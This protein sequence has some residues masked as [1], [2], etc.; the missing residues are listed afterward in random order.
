[1]AGAPFCGW[2]QDGARDVMRDGYL[3]LV[4]GLEWAGVRCQ[5]NRMGQNERRPRPESQVPAV[6]TLALP[7]CRICIGGPREDGSRNLARRGGL[8]FC[9]CFMGSDLRV[10]FH[11]SNSTKHKVERSFSPQDSTFWDRAL[12]L[13]ALP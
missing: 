11:V 7:L 3:Q 9:K 6:R 12:T 13:S 5:G 2:H 10:E 4:R 8:K 1:M